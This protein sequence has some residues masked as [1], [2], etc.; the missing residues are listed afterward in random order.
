[1]ILFT[2]V[3]G[4]VNVAPE[5]IGAIALKNGVTFGVTV[6]AINATVAH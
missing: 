1:M 4:N 3:V 5:Q 2:E 6:T